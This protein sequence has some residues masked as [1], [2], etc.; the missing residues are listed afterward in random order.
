MPIVYIIIPAFNEEKTIGNVIDQ[1]RRYYSDIVVV[2][3]GS[4]DATSV[5]AKQ[6]GAAVLQHRINRGQ[7]AALETGDEY[8]RQNNAD[9]VVHFDADGQFLASEIGDLVDALERGHLDIVIGSRFLEKKSHLPLLKNYL[10]FPIARVINRIFFNIRLT[11]PQCGFRALTK[12]ALKNI[13][14]ENDGMAHCNEIIVKTLRYNLSFREVPITVI[15]NEFGQS[16][17]GGSKLLKDMLLTK[18]LK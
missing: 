9:I 18:F 11:D 15:Y 13:T 8:A 3:D 17:G 5:I 2:D 16:I 1:V 12:N 14:I 7:G 4:S 10:L 6:H